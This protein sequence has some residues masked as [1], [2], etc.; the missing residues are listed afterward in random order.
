ME[1]ATKIKEHPDET[2]MERKARLW[3]NEK[4]EEYKSGA[5]GAFSDLMEGGCQSGIVGELVYYSDTLSF[6][7]KYRG[8]INDLFFETLDNKYPNLG[9]NT[10]GGSASDLFGNKWEKEDPLA[11][12]TNNQNLLA[13]FGF[14]EA[15]LIVAQRAG[16]EY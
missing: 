16:I 9:I 13:W 11:Q 12:K 1:T 5:E 10:Y 15:A 2:N 3:L 14:E 7:K 8:E 4:G 6:F